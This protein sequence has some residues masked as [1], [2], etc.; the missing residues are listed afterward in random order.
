M[1]KIYVVRKYVVANSVE[2]A[3][4][5]EKNAKV[6]DCWMEEQTQKHWLDDKVGVRDRMGFNHNDRH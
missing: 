4:E 2:D 6:D 1:K 5:K 3:L